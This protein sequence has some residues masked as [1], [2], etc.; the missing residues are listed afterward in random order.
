MADAAPPTVLL[1]DTLRAEKVALEPLVPGQVSIYCCGPTVYDVSHLGHARAA[2][3]P[4]VLVRTLQAVGLAVRYA[5]NVTDVDDKIIRRAAEQGV[6]P[7]EIATRY[8]AAYR[9]D[10]AALG[11]L[12]PTVEPTVTGHMPQ[13]LA[14]IERLFAA[15]LAYARDGDV[16]YRVRAFAGYG[17]L[18]KRRLE[19]M[20]AGARVDVDERKDD[21]MDFALWKAAKPGE[22]AWDSPWGPGRPGW[23]IECSAMS[24][25]HL[26]ESFD[27]H[28]GGRDLIFPHHENEIAQS[29]GACG[30]HTYARLWVHNGFVNFGG[31]K[32]SKSL[33][34][35]FTIRQITQLY[36]P[37]VLRAY[38]LGVHYRSGVNFDV[39]LLDAS[40]APMAAA[41]AA[42][43]P[44]ATPEELRRRV[45]FPGLEEADER[46][47]YVYETI[48]AAQA[49]VGGADPA[50]E[51]GAVDPSVEGL[52]AR[53]LAALCDDLNT[54]RALAE[55]SEP[56]AC[57]NRLVAT[58]KGVD[59]GLRRR[60][61]ARF[62]R[63]IGQISGWLG[64]YARDPA[65]F[66]QARRDLK[67]ARVGLDVAA[68]E[69]LVSEREAARTAR[70]WPAAD[71][72][73]DAL[74]SMGV[75][76]RDGAHGSSWTL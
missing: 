5:R 33:G 40:G 13:I 72:L 23:H 31:E 46:T 52:A 20:Q 17:Q 42:L 27:I 32:M 24:M 73:R 74:G 75:T 14:L 53:V 2:L 45:R 49:A 18:S 67:A 55:L 4:D 41:E 50:D 22:P 43:A 48:A 10:L 35:F 16:Y 69:R 60:T 39:E 8:A 76:V 44:D 61:L 68:V 51:P 1:H 7:D 47:A 64:L 34:N 30:P 54:A 3:V 9:E 21:P 37:E 65:A 26:G 6:T 38:L 59:K 56:L 36:H 70:D 71:R 57:V 58:A 19:D 66:L 28:A 15:G 11:M 12:P 62:V 25:E 63:E 29:Q